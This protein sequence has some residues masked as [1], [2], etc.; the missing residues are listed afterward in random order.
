MQV[1][2]DLMT[3]TSKLGCVFLI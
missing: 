1:V 3:P 2:K